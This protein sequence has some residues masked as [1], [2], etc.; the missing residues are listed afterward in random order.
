MEFDLTSSSW[1][2]RGFCVKN[3][4]EIETEL[5]SWF[6]LRLGRSPRDTYEDSYWHYPEFSRGKCTTDIIK[7]GYKCVSPSDFIR[8]IRMNEH[9]DVALK[10]TLETTPIE[11][12]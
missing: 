12:W 5:R 9:I 10:I 2:G 1:D 11:L 8:A 3:N 7:S 4:P 6:E